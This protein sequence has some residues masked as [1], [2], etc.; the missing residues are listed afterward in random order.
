MILSNFGDFN[1]FSD[2]GLTSF[3]YRNASASKKELTGGHCSIKESIMQVGLLG[4]LPSNEDIFL[5]F[6]ECLLKSLLSG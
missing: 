1:D 2:F 5:T 6:M 4:F 3:G